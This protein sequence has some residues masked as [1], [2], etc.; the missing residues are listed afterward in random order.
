MG[1]P[2][3]TCCSSSLPA[4]FSISYKIE[5]EHPPSK[6]PLS[7]YALPWEV[8]TNGSLSASVSVTVILLKCLD[9]CQLL[10][11][12]VAR[13]WSNEL[14]SCKQLSTHSLITFDYYWLAWN[15]GHCSWGEMSFN[16]FHN[17]WIYWQNVAHNVFNNRDV[18]NSFDS[19]I[20]GFDYFCVKK[21]A[22]FV[23]LEDD[24]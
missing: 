15:Y 7:F 13:I 22:D 23:P 8:T 6:L 3:K 5:P 9:Y 14:I 2:P 21:P 4:K 1:V 16:W 19:E 11:V 12:L 10:I 24:L 20:P 17:C 18:I